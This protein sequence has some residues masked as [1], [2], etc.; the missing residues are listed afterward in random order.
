M[1][2][3]NT[4]SRRTRP[5]QQ[6]PNVPVSLPR[7]ASLFGPLDPPPPLDPNLFVLD[8]GSD[9]GYSDGQDPWRYALYDSFLG[10]PAAFPMGGTPRLTRRDYRDDSAQRRPQAEHPSGRP[11]KR[12]GTLA[13][14]G[15]QR[16]YDRID[17]SLSVSKTILGASSRSR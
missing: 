12:S 4:K 10:T 2:S 14:S 7:P 15:S 5:S 3:A 9:H 17:N 6:L 1:S 11:I 13:Q 16:G 8:W